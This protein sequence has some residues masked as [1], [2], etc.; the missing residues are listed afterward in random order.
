MAGK[1][2]DLYHFIR[3][4]VFD[5]FGAPSGAPALNPLNQR[6]AVQPAAN[7]RRQ[8]ESPISPATPRPF[9]PPPKSQHMRRNYFTPF[10]I[11]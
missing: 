9:A 8:R 11:M 7:T 4:H 6:D 5:E 1:E 10:D 3:P 2:E